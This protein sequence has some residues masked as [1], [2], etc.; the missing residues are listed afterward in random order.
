MSEVKSILARV[1]NLLRQQ[2]GNMMPMS[3]FFFLITLIMTFSLINVTHYYIE[4]RHLILVVESAL[5][6][7]SQNLDETAYY[8]GFDRQNRYR[9]SVG[10]ERLLLPIDC[11]K[12]REDFPKKF[13]EHWLLNQDL[14]PVKLDRSLPSV[15]QVSCDGMSLTSTVKARVFFP[16]P[17][18]FAGVSF[19]E[20]MEQSVTVAVGSVVGG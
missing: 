6:S 5:E 7:A 12:A 2:A 4:R 15:V 1:K 16:F 14:N 8:L 20:S 18:A 13:R 10:N 11:S 9:D 17:V 3:F 19:Y